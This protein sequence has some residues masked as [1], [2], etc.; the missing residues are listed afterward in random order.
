MLRKCVCMHSRFIENHLI[1]ILEDRLSF[2]RWFCHSGDGQSLWLRG[3]TYPCPPDLVV[4]SLE[5]HGQVLEI[6]YD[7]SECTQSAAVEHHFMS[8]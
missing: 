5:C 4:K 8:L 2:L 6:P 7:G 3:G 1:R